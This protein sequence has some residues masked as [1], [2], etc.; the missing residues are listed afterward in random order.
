MTSGRVGCSTT[1]VY[2][3]TTA[4]CNGTAAATTTRVLT[5][6]PV[7][8]KPVTSSSRLPAFASFAT[9][10]STKRCVSRRLFRIRLRAPRGLK[11]SKATV[12]VDGRV[13]ATRRGARLT[14]PV[15][16]RG[17]PKGRFSVSI[18]LRLADGRSVRATRR[19]RT[20]A[21]KRRT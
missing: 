11:L 1:Q 18:E 2:T 5:V 4:Y 20:C 10:P 16:L 3:G 6:G 7:A 17:L 21:P 12:K 15:D 19:Y 8:P 9:L 14:A 13:V